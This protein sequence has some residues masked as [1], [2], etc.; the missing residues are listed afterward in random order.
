M[1]SMDQIEGEIDAVQGCPGNRSLRTQQLAIPRMQELITAVGTGQVVP[2]TLWGGPGEISRL[3]KEEPRL[4]IRRGVLGRQWV[5]PG[6]GNT[7]QAYIPLPLRQEIMY[8]VHN[9]PLAA[10]LG[11]DRTLSALRVMGF[12]PGC[13]RDVD[14]YVKGCDTCQ[15]KQRKPRAIDRDKLCT[16]TPDYP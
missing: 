8:Q 13:V 3:Q 12:W 4:E 9:G 11:A 16:M 15:K 2:P 10:H 14:L 1:I 7:W 6:K 5:D